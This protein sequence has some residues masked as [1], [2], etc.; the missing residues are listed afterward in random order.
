MLVNSLTAET[1]TI[2]DNVIDFYG[3]K[4]QLTV[5]IEE[6]SELIKELC[7]VQRGIPNVDN[8]AEE[9]ADVKIVL[10]QLDI[11]INNHDEVEKWIKKKLDRLKH[12]LEEDKKKEGF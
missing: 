1:N 11:I 6:L 8:I 12:R 10:A 9:M 7:K 4:N 2:F 5:C 3:A